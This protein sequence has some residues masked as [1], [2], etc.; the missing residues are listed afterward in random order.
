V[1]VS[2]LFF[3]RMK[4]LNT[5]G[6]R[7]YYTK[8][9]LRG[10]F[11]PLRNPNQ[12]ARQLTHS[13]ELRVLLEKPPVVQLFKNCIFYGVWRFITVFTRTLHWS[14]FWAK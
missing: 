9:C 10:L 13:R 2:N 7:N 3:Q 5:W 12:L 6:T 8:V 14:L 4:N 1:I 11:Q